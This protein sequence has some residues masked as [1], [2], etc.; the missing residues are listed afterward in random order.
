MAMHIT[1]KENVTMRYSTSVVRRTY[2][3]NEHME[4]SKELDVPKCDQTMLFKVYLN[5]VW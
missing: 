3:T 2:Y 5:S 1:P 4:N